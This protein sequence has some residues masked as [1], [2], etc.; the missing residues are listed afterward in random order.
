MYTHVLWLVLGYLGGV[1]GM[2]ARQSSIFIHEERHT[3][4][5]LPQD[6]PNVTES[7]Y[8]PLTNDTDDALF[9][10]YYTA[11]GATADSKDGT[12]I[13]VWLQG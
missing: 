8:I 4:S 2:Y 10:A 12:P 1:A 11:H 9:Y 7:G 5:R 6:L 3:A 13:I